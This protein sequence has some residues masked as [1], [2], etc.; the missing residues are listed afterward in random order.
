MHTSWRDAT[1]RTVNSTL[2]H[3]GYRLSV[4][5]NALSILEP[6]SSVMSKWTDPDTLTS[7]YARRDRDRMSQVRVHSAAGGQKPAANEYS[8]SPV[9]TAVAVACAGAFAF[10]FHLGVVNGPLEAIASDL[11][12]AGDK[13]LQGM[14]GWH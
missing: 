10:G 12:F 13:A 4:P 6:P 2:M 1:A 8:L 5:E 7:A 11:G 14:V 9:L 3:T